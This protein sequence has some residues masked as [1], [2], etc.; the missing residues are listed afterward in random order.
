MQPPISAEAPARSR[1]REK[2]VVL[3]REVYS[4]R[5]GRSSPVGLLPSR[6]DP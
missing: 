5:A 3:I 1:T 2:A 4:R 6:A